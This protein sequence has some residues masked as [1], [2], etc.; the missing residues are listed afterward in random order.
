[1][2]ERRGAAVITGGGTGMGLAS[3]KALAEA[4]F[5]LLI[6]GRRPQVL[7][8]ARK[9]ITDA[10]P[11]RAVATL[12]ADVGI[13][14]QALGIV[15]QA[16]AELGGL[17]V[18]VTAA[19]TYAP[20][21]LLEMTVDQWD[22]TI[23]VALRGTFI[24]AV[25]AARH[26]KEHAGGRI[27]LFGSTDS[28]ESEP[29]VAHYNAAKAGVKSLA[30]SMAVELAPFGISVNAVGPG[31]VRT[32]MVEEFLSQATPESLRRVNPL[33]R[34]ADPS[35]IASLVRYLA[36]EAPPFLTG[37]LIMIDGGQTIMA[38]MP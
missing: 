30:H 1:M 24:C 26:M 17:D 9:A 2:A 13:P 37:S 18:M 21:S 12:S 38:P 7:A 29:D 8:D 14:D 3:A 28:V 11:E 33:G 25:A 10:H 34:W 36:T 16:V 32:P 6:A 27:I 4:G 5:D 20:V 19:A 23:N 31:W 35:E 15:G 22:S